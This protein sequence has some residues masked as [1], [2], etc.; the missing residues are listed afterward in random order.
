MCI[1]FDKDK[2]HCYIVNIIFSLV[3]PST[4]LDTLLLSVDVVY[5]WWITEFHITSKIW[6]LSLLPVFPAFHLK[7][8]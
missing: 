4:S 2:A 8:K 5:T 1:D 7:K 6:N 3:P